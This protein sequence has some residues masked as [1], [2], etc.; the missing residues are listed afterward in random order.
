MFTF[1]CILF[2]GGKSSRMGRDKALLPFGGFDTLAEYQ[3]RR[4]EPLFASVY[5]SVKHAENLPFDAPVIED[6]S[7]VFAPTAGFA[8]AFKMLETDR[9]FVLSVDAP[10]LG[11]TEMARLIEADRPDL[12]AVIAETAAG[13]HPMC[14]IY[15]QS[16][17]TEF[18]KM[19]Q[20][21]SH[22]LGKMLKEARTRHVFFDDE[23]PFTNLNHP[24]EYETA[25]KMQRGG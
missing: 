23:T 17:Q 5:L 3:Y 20:Q 24:H 14:G 6:G 18:E 11:E 25:V 4:L 1:P 21:N 8:A 7:D 9:F 22:K 19:L 10:L 15:H 2:A 13:T 12:D 16:L